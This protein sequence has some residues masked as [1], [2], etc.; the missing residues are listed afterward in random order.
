M[1]MSY[2][3]K[4]VLENTFLI[5]EFFYP[6]NIVATL[7]ITYIVRNCLSFVIR[8]TVVFSLHHYYINV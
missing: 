1:N 3:D 7:G 4:S 5:T 2:V 8:R 6:F